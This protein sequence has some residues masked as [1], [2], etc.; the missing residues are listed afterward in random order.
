MAS[1]RA[2]AQEAVRAGLVR[3]AGTAATKPATLVADDVAVELVARRRAIRLARRTEARGRARAVRGRPRR[4]RVPRRRRVDGRVH[5]LPAAGRRAPRRRRRRRL[6]AARLDASHRRPRDGARA[7]ERPAPRGRRPSVPGRARRGRSVVH[8]AAARSCPPSPAV[9]ASDAQRDVPGEAAVRGRAQSASAAAAW[10]AIPTVWASGD[11]R[12]WSTA[13]ERSGFAPQGLMAS[14][15]RGPAGNVEFLLWAAPRRGGARR[16][17]SRP[18][19]PKAARWLH[20]PGRA[21]DASERVAA[22]VEAAERSGRALEG[23]GTIAV[24]LADD[25]DAPELDRRARPGG[26]RRRRRHVPAGRL[27][28]VARRMPGA[29]REGRTDGVPH[30]GRAATT[31]CP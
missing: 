8:L 10:C 4:A 29:R 9:A 12:A 3:I 26:Q 15:V 19:S 16:S 17:T 1:S 7:H 31:P 6:R 14:P 11:R 18:P 27:R 30:R 25:G 5:G 20:E 23:E 22:A 13:A 28:R 21:G 24:A 2:E